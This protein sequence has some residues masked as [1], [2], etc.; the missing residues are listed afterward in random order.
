M[1]ARSTMVNP[2]LD[3][4]TLIIW[5][6]NESYDTFGL[7]NIMTIFGK[8]IPQGFSSTMWK[9]TIASTRS[10]TAFPLTLSCISKHSTN[11]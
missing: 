4:I 6:N 2:F 3:L 5:L 9:S 1:I 8:A 10:A 7:H 11:T